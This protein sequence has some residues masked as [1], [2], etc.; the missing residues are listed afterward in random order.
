MILL[1][2]H[3]GK[4]IINS[5]S[6]L[7]DSVVIL[8]NVHFCKWRGDEVNLTQEL[9]YVCM[10]NHGSVIK[11]NV[12]EKLLLWFTAFE[13]SSLNSF[14]LSTSNHKIINGRCG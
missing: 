4:K 14:I 1:T 2:S 13:R 8:Q 6:V 3:Q 7:A 11:L 9:V 10:G 5:F 12:D